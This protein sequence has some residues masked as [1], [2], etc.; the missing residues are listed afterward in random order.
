MPGDCRK[1]PRVPVSLLPNQ[2]SL[3]E[4]DGAI[5]PHGFMRKMNFWL[6]GPLARSQ[7]LLCLL[8][9]L[10]KPIWP[11]R[12]FLCSSSSKDCSDFCLFGN[13]PETPQE[14]ICHPGNSH[15]L[16]HPQPNQDPTYSA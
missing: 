9:G 5:A 2:Q 3:N 1:V 7:L 12:L 11:P 13:P 14:T 6:S 10:S 8:P 15:P 4:E 16:V